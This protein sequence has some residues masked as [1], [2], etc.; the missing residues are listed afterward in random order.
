[1]KETKSNTNRWRDYHVLG[2]K[3]YCEHNYTTQNNL[4]IQCN[5]YQVTNGIFHRTRTKTVIICM[6]TQKTQK[7]QSNFERERVRGIRL[8]DFILY[9]KATVIKTVV[10]CTV[11]KSCLTPLWPHGLQ[12]ASLHR[13]FTRKEYWRGLPFPPFPSPEDLSNPWIQLKSLCTGWQILYNSATKEA[14][15]KRQWHQNQDCRAMKQDWKTKDKPMHIWSSN[16]W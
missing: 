4:H 10:Y 2:S 12:P 5:P 16:L 7:S 15:I 8:P 13:G 11:A 14:P 1:M 3:E 6:E 9:Y